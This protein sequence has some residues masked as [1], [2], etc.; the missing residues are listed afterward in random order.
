MNIILSDLNSN[1][2]VAEVV[3]QIIG[4]YKNK[5][6][7]FVGYRPSSELVSVVDA[8]MGQGY[9][10]SAIITNLPSKTCECGGRNCACEMLKNKLLPENLFIFD[11]TQHPDLL[12]I[13]P[14]LGAAVI[15][16]INTDHPQKN[17]IIQWIK[18]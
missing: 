15:W 3:G 13:M 12:K 5:P 14:K 7:Y 16:V 4:Q 9:Y 6:V 2:Q 10:Q 1:R 11:K 17:E 8:I 18:S